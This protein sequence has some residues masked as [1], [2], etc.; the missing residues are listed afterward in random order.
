LNHLVIGFEGSADW[1]SVTST[2]TT[3]SPLIANFLHQGFGN[4]DSLFSVAG[5]VGLAWR[6]LLIYA[7]GG[8]VWDR[9]NGNTN[10]FL[11]SVLTS[12]AQTP[13]H[14]TSGWLLGAGAEWMLDRKWSV[15]AEYDYIDLGPYSFESV[16]TYSTTP[17]LVGTSAASLGNWKINTFVTGLNYHY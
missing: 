15:K 2:Q 16:I 8:G 6:S 7:K 13:E 4:I 10:N 5:R 9:V 17:G 12:Q 11:G 1:A 3:S 14:S